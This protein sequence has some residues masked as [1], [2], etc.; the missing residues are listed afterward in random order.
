M[1]KGRSPQRGREVRVRV[2]DEMF[3]ADK[4]QRFDPVE[5]PLAVHDA[6]DTTHAE[7]EHQ[8]VKWKGRLGTSH[9]FQMEERPC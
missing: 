2:G 4:R 6:A 9:I 8:R 7:G 1:F 3:H 5:S